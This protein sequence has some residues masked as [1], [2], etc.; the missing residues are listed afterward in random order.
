MDLLVEVCLSA[1]ILPPLRRIDGFIG[2]SFL[3]CYWMLLKIRIFCEV[4]LCGS[5]KIVTLVEFL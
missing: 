1:T 5:L 4:V 2:Q 3:M